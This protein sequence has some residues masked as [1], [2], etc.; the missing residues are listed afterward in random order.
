MQE[1]PIPLEINKARKNF[2]LESVDYEWRAVHTMFS[3][4]MQPA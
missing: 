3:C 1:A 2:N 4:F